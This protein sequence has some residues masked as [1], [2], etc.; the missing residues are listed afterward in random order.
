MF[1]LILRLHGVVLRRTLSALDLAN[2]AISVTGSEPDQEYH[3]IES[4][5]ISMH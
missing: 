4:G 2:A 5:S 1:L 3:D